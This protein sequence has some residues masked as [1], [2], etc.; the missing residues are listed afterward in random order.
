MFHDRVALRS[1]KAAL[2]IIEV[3]DK[4]VS[5]LDYV[6]LSYSFL[7]EL[8]RRYAELPATRAMVSV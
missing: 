8:R 4:Y 5:S 7:I 2:T 6:F 1:Q 3:L